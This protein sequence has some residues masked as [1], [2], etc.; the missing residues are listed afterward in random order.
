MFWLH[1]T[2]TQSKCQHSDSNDYLRASKWEQIYAVIQ[3]DNKISFFYVNGCRWF[4]SWKD[5]FHNSSQTVENY[6][7]KEGLLFFKMRK[8]NFKKKKSSVASLVSLCFP[9]IEDQYK[10]FMKVT[11]T[12]IHIA[13]PLE[14]A[15]QR[16]AVYLI[17]FRC[18]CCELSNQGQ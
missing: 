15:V 1:C 17:F 14:W 12:P 6:Q 9:S 18:Y 8:L 2:V 7:F 4:T 5:N 13:L 11:H 10:C 16:S 3:Q